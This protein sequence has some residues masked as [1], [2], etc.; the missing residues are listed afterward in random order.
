[1]CSTVTDNAPL[2]IF[3]FI[4]GV[5]S[6]EMTLKL[7]LSEEVRHHSACVAAGKR[8]VTGDCSSLVTRLSRSV[9][10]MG[11]LFERPALP[12]CEGHVDK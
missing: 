3:A 7:A 2:R 5:A 8:A 1:M 9:E 11:V 6:F 12:S 4:Y 10:E